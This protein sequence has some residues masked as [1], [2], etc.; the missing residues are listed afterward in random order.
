M[1]F[2]PDS[3]PGM[4]DADAVTDAL[5]H[6]S[7]LLVAVSARSIASVDESITLPQYRLLVV[8]FNYGPLKL[9]TLAEHLGVNP[10]TATRMI[11]RLIAT[12]LATR[13]INP[14]SRR[15]VVV[16]L[17]DAGATVVSRATSR[18]RDEIADIVARMPDHHRRDLVA[19][20]ESFADAG[21]EPPASMTP[22]GEVASLYR[23]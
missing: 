22:L 6:A 19:A 7:R 4:D 17:T 9:A 23:I 21:G 8:L 11:D 12:R 18:R 10:S 3:D 13:Q 20:L 1:V 14:S 16:E 5:L 2:G 15:E